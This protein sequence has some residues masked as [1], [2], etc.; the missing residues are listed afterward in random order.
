MTYRL[1]R[2]ILL[3]ILAFWLFL[4]YDYL[5]HL[6]MCI[7]IVACLI[8]LDMLIIF[9]VYYLDHL[10]ACYS[11]V[12]SSQ[13]FCFLLS[14]CVDMNDIFILCMTICYMTSFFSA[15]CL[16]CQSTWDTYLSPYSNSLVS[17]DLVSLDL[18]FHETCCFVCFPTKL[19]IQSRV[20]WWA[21]PK[22]ESILE[23]ADILMLIRVQSSKTCT[24]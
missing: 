24:T 17:V 15:W 5:I 12:Y 9:V 6:D 2:L 14:L 20:Q 3:L 10:W 4:L 1:Y 11:Y 7:L 18:V 23:G 8:H 21:I 13:L 19:M 22:F 16:H